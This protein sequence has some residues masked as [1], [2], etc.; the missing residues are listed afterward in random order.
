M[1]RPN[2]KCASFVFK[3]PAV[4]GVSFTT[5]GRGTVACAQTDA[6][7][8]LPVLSSP[9]GRPCLILWYRW[10]CVPITTYEKETC[11]EV[12]H[13]T[14]LMTLIAQQ[15]RWSCCCSASPKENGGERDEVFLL[16]VVSLCMWISSFGLWRIC[17]I[18]NWILSILLASDCGAT[19][20]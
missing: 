14:S 10:I 6:R 9:F 11:K 18:G 16:C 1:T 13:A 20:H 7:G 4:A 19:R 2:R 15:L 8:A 17:G 3:E 5:V 12:W